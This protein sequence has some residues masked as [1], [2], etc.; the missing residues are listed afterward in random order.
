MIGLK[1]SIQSFEE[2]KSDIRGQLDARTWS[3]AQ[4]YE[5]NQE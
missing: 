1:N 2:E 5:E 4:L 3:R